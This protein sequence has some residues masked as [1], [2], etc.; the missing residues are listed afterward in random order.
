MCGSCRPSQGLTPYPLP[1]LPSHG[2]AP[3]ALRGRFLPPPR[4][5]SS[6][7]LNPNACAPRK[8]FST[9]KN[10]CGQKMMK[11]LNWLHSLSKVL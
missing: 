5:V 8:P 6:R 4:P 11:W 7:N 2:L 9:N 3:V 1:S 10:S